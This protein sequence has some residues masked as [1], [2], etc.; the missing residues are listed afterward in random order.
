M[1][2]MQI[3][4]IAALFASP[5]LAFDPG[6][7]GEPFE[8]TG[9]MQGCGASEELNGCSFYAEG[10]R[11]MVAR[12]AGTDDAVLDAM[13]ALPVNAPVVVTGDMISMG[14]ITVE[15]AVS[16]VTPGT[17][18]AY[19]ALRDAMQGDW[20]SQDDASSALKI[21]GSEQQEIY[22]GEALSLSVVTF[23]EAC[24][25][26]EPMGTVFYTHEMG[27]DP[28]DFYCY[29]VVDLTPE[30]MELSYFGRGNTL[31]YIRP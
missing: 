27:A 23:A 19:A 7:Y 10:A 2:Q 24:P 21:T 3:I 12:G 25:E 16:T 9:L 5:A 28:A 30:R 11:W 22:A 14:D 6:T 8:V 31:V 4:A 15:A 17:P 1:K 26:G 18:D 13:A 20:V 29:A